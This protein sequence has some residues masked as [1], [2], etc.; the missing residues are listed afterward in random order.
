MNGKFDKWNPCWMVRLSERIVLNHLTSYSVKN[1]KKVKFSTPDIFLS[2]R[3]IPRAQ[4][5]IISLCITLFFDKIITVKIWANKFVV[6]N[7][8]AVFT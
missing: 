8:Y 1:H 7:Y 3:G 6:V 5:P 2:L 4:K